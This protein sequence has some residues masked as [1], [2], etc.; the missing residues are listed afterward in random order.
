MYVKILRIFSDFSP[1]FHGFEHRELDDT[2]APPSYVLYRI[3][4]VL[5]LITII[6]SQLVGLK[7][8]RCCQSKHY[9]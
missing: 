8:G 4:Q 3:L 1:I 7:A 2:V 5:Y 9:Y 6:K